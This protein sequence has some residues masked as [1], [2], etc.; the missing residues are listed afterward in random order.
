MREQLEELIKKYR[1]KT[2]CGHDPKHCDCYRWD[3][4]KNILADELQEILNIKRF[5][6]VER[7]EKFKYKNRLYV[8]CEP[9]QPVE[10]KVKMYCNAV[11]IEFGN[12]KVALFTDAT[13]VETIQS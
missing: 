9:I 4:I 5:C 6:E 8:K 12:G 3:E 7:G 11:C 10:A 1:E 13:E 2:Q